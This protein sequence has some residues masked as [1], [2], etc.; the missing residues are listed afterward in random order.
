MVELSEA[1]IYFTASKS[2]RFPQA[3]KSLNQIELSKSG[4][5]YTTTYNLGQAGDISIKAQTLSLD[6]GELRIGVD[7]NP[8]PRAALTF[9][10]TSLGSNSVSPANSGNVLVEAQ[11]LKVSNGAQFGTTSL[12]TGQAE[13]VTVNASDSVIVE[14]TARFT[15]FDLDQRLTP[16]VRQNLLR[17]QVDPNRVT[18]DRAAPSIIGSGGGLRNLFTEQVTNFARIPISRAGSVTINSPKIQINDA[19]ITVQNAGIGDAGT[20]TINADQVQLNR[21]GSI[22]ASTLSG[23]GGNIAL[24]VNQLWLQDKAEITTNAGAGGNGGSIDLSSGV[25]VALKDSR[26]SANAERGQGGNVRITAQG[27][28]IDRGSSISATSERGPEFNGTIQINALDSGIK[29]SSLRTVPSPERPTIATICP[30]QA[31]TRASA[32]IN[33]GTGGIPSN[34][35]DVLSSRQGWLPPT[36]GKS[37][38]LHSQAIP[39][40]NPSIEIQGWALNSDR[41][42]IR[43]VTIAHGIPQANGTLPCSVPA[44]P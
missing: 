10:P 23:N 3:D 39:R 34:P 33:N 21:G 11:Q 36:D 2:S 4:L 13:T 44:S 16:D 35:S 17:F 32:L 31:D 29:Q 42:T 6:G 14:G 8:F 40:S 18:V 26:I 20:L 19:R 1:V 27:V 7:N 9:V 43:L 12:V 37:S 25:L 22:A 5:V 30:S 24:N 41:K 28:F 15:Q 38:A